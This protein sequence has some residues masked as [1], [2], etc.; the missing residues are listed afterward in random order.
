MGVVPHHG[1]VDCGGRRGPV[2]CSPPRQDLLAYVPTPSALHIHRLSWQRLLS[3]LLP[4]GAN[5][6]RLAWSPSGALFSVADSSGHL[7][8]WRTEAGVL[9]QRRFVGTVRALAWTATQLDDAAAL[10]ARDSQC[11]QHWEDV[12]PVVLDAAADP[13]L[14]YAPTRLAPVPLLEVAVLTLDDWVE[15]WARGACR[16]GRIAAPHVRSA[17]LAPDL[18]AV[19][20]VAWDADCATVCCANTAPLAARAVDV[21][22]I[23]AH[24]INMTSLADAL[25]HSTQSARAAWRRHMAAVS[26]VVS[27]L[28][29]RLRECESAD[30]VRSAIVDV[31]MCGTRVEGTSLWLETDLGERGAAKLAKGIQDG[32]AAV[33]EMLDGPLLNVAEQLCF[34]A[35]EMAADD[36]LCCAELQRRCEVTFAQLDAVAVQ[37][38]AARDPLLSFGRWLWRTHKMIAFEEAV[39]SD[40]TRRPEAEAALNAH[41]IA[42]PFD[43]LHVM[44]FAEMCVTNVGDG[45]VRC[46]AAFFLANL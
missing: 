43:E 10:A 8:L 33:L 5:V 41:R 37:V 42:E 18:R 19:V 20:Y 2:F 17:W 23:A 34:R 7:L 6:Q 3:V 29:K 13:P 45:S 4:A 35:A 28:H 38:R 24:A 1:C 25:A 11:V 21:A 31:L 22:G 30:D 15:L 16:I 40:A 44:A 32:F 26:D 36:E 27:A 9:L 14:L 46:G 39:K 12:V